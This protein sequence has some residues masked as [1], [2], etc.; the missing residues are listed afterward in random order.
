MTKETDGESKQEK[1]PAENSS[2]PA[3]RRLRRD[4]L[5][6]PI[7]KREPRVGNDFQVSILPTPQDS[8]TRD[9]ESTPEPEK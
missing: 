9:S 8:A 3:A 1:R 7:G 2:E 5:A 4:W 6:A